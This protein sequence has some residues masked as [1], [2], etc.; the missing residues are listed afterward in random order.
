MD[1]NI[2]SNE[3]CI[4]FEANWIDI[5][6]CLKTNTSNGLSI[7]SKI[8]NIKNNRNFSVLPESILFLLCEKFDNIIFKNKSIIN[9]IDVDFENK[10][11]NNKSKLKR[12]Y[13]STTEQKFISINN[14]KSFNYHEFSNTN[15]IKYNNLE[16]TNS[17][18]NMIKERKKTLNYFKEFNDIN[19]NEGNDIYISKIFYIYNGKIKFYSNNKFIKELNSNGIFADISYGINSRMN[20][21]NIMLAEGDV[22]CY[23][24]DVNFFKENVDENYF[25]YIQ[26]ILV[27]QDISIELRN[28]FYVKTLGKGKYGQV[29]LVHNR[30]NIY[31]LKIANIED[32]KKKPYLIRYYLEEKLIMQEIDHPFIVIFVKTIKNESRLFFLMEFIDGITLQYYIEKKEIKT[33]RNIQEVQFL[34]GIL[35]LIT[36]YLHKKRIIHRDI[37]PRNIIMDNSV[38]NI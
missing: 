28:L 32:I 29:L 23:S 11:N 36:N 35:L 38:I 7:L 5:L 22:K 31:A 15:S 17:S 6:N 33:L 1:H 20:N 13:S 16:N 30:K 37:K 14:I 8:S 10:I 2:I 26:S 27:L 24:I 21:K 18:N 12:N 9:L 3:E 34:G 25:N 19:I 4:I